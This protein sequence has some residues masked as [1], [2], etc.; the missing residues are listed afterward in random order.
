MVQIQNALLIL[1]IISQLFETIVALVSAVEE[2]LPESGQGAQKL[3]LVK[4]W[5]QSAIGAQEALALTFDQLWPALQTT[6]ASIVAIK[7]A[8]GVFKKGS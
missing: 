2:A 4:G 8:T 6:I 1:Q 7:N 3:E 5:L